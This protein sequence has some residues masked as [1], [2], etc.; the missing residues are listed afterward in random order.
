M[1]SRAAGIPSLAKQEAIKYI[2]KWQITGHAVNTQKEEEMER[3]LDQE[4]LNSTEPTSR[5]MFNND[6]GKSLRRFKM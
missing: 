2:V 1:D 3:A 5:T 6:M 4:I